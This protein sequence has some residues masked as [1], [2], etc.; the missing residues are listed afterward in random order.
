MLD[1]DN[2]TTNFSVTLVTFALA[3]Y[4][5][6]TILKLFA[7]QTCPRILYKLRKRNSHVYV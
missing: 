6:V 3:P 2:N 1:T 7:A 5:T 4:T